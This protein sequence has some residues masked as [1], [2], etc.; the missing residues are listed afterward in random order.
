[1]IQCPKIRLF[2]TTGWRSGNTQRVHQPDQ[3]Q[4]WQL[5]RQLPQAKAKG[6]DIYEY[7]RDRNLWFQTLIFR[8][9]SVRARDR[10]PF[11]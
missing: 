3:D 2:C 6:A 9:D 5:V 10:P 7:L 11:H 4:L 1:M 8:C